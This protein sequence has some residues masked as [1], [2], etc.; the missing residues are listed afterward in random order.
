MEVVLVELH[1]VAVMHIDASAVPALQCEAV[2]GVQHTLVGVV[3]PVVVLGILTLL[4]ADDV[5]VNLVADAHSHQT[6]A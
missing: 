4:C 6:E 3:G 1:D 5:L 2:F